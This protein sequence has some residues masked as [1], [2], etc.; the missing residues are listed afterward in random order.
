[1][2][3]PD[4]ALI[5][6][7]TTHAPE[8]S[9]AAASNNFWDHFQPHHAVTVREIYR[10]VVTWKP[11]FFTL[12]KNKTGEQFA[13]ALHSV[14][15][16]IAVNT[17]RS[18]SPLTFCMI[19]PHLA[20]SRTKNTHDGSNNKTIK[21]RLQAWYSFNFSELFCEAKA[22]Q[23]RM[24]SRNKQQHS[25]LKMFNDF[26]SRGKISNAIRVLSDEHKG[27]VL[28]P[29][30][31]IDGRPVLEILRDKHPEGQPLEPSCIQS[32]HPR[33]LP[34]HP[35][36]FDKISARLVRKHAMKTHGS[37]GPSGLDADDWRRLLSAFGQTS[38][39]LCKLV[40][41]FAKRLATSTIPPDDLITY[42]GCRLVALDKCAGVRTIDIGEV[43]RRIT[44]RIIV[45]CIRQD[46]TSLGGTM[47]LCLGQKCG[48]EHAIHSLRHSFDDPENEAILL[49]DSK[50]AFNVLN[51]R[52]ALENVK[53]LCPSLHVAL[54]NSYSHPSH[55]Y[56]GKSTIL[57]QEGT[58]Q[59][60]PLAMA[61]YGIAIL[62]LITRLHNDSLTQKW[63]ADDGSVVGKLK[64]I[65]ALFDKLTELGPKYG[66]LVNPPKC[67]LIIKPGGE[68]QAST[69]FAGTNVEITQGARVLGSVIGSSE[70]SKN[71]LKDAETKYT[72]SLDRLGQFAL[73]S[74]QNAYACLTKGVQQKL[75]FLS[76]T[77]PSMDGVLDKVEERLGRVI[78]NIVG[79]EVIQEERTFF[80][81]SEWVGLTSPSHKIFTKILSNQLNSQDHWRHSIIFNNVK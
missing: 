52:T 6:P 31:L 8:R 76:R 78:P 67:Q 2:T 15:S 41:K 48:I 3:V 45:D 80:S 29:T 35:A 74:P 81:P 22:I 20:L 58:T 33:T 50:N 10:E 26:M 54:Q 18:D 11:S 61:M 79:K 56:I 30:D 64:D 71:F 24:N 27:G 49:I 32:E 77:T 23:M 5:D 9:V 25:D 69:V 12:G 57:S 75:S 68:R 63:Y 37:A 42:N 70:A 4:T 39:N 1:M 16:L 47:Q 28:A 51:R 53:A 44:G 40:A 55:L 43:M 59:G 34:Y 14:L 60:D 66:Y 72:K 13:E 62:P 65:R 17:D 73:T 7:A 36:V 46:L 19:L 38:T 21:R